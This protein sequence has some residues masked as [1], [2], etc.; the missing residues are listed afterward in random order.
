MTMRALEQFRKHLKCGR[1]YRR[2]DL[3][4]YSSSVD[5]HLAALVKEGFLT[6]VSNGM[7]SR[8]VITEF[9]KTLPKEH[10]LLETF[11]KDDH[12]VVYSMSMFNSLGLGTTQL[13]SKRIVFN[14]KRL[15]IFKLGGHTYHFFRWREAPKKLTREFLVV[16]FLNKLEMLAEDHNAA[17]KKL[18]E[19]LKSFKANTLKKY[20]K[21]YGTYSSQLK[22]K[23]LLS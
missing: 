11:L 10:K 5:R 2:G 21:K 1:Y 9:G 3:V 19:K 13:Y 8:P 4:R 22:F 6:K 23:T 17:L 14:R 18:K 16:E 12:F 15:G 7:Y 20:V